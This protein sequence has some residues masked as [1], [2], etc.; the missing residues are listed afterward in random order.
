MSAMSGVMAPSRPVSAPGPMPSPFSLP[1][2]ALRI[3][4]KCALPLIAWFSAGQAVRFGLL[5]LG[6]EISHGDARQL[7]LV[8]TIAVLTLIVMASM[9]ITAGMLWSVRGALWEIRARRATGEEDERYWVSMN[10]V[11]P[12]F[13]VIYLTWGFH[14]EDA[15][16]F[17]QTDFL[18][19]IDDF[20]S[21]SFLGR[22]STVGR[23]LIDLD[24]RISFGLMAVAFLLRALF[25]KMV[26][27]GDGKIS[28]LGTALSEFA[29][30]FFG[31]NATFVLANARSDW[32]SHRL[33]VSASGELVTQAEQS[34][35]GWEA[36]WGAVGEIWPYI[37]DG[38]FIPLTWLTVAVLVFGTYAD[39][40]RTMLRDTR[41]EKGIDKLYSTHSITQ[42]SV[43]RITG[44]FQERWVPLANSF[45]QTLTGG[46][47]LFGM[48]CLCYVSL[49]VGAE[50]AMR[51]VRTLIGS[52]VE[53][54]WMLVGAPVDF[55]KNLL[56]TV[57]TMALLAA[58]FDIAAT[59]GRRMAP[60][61]EAPESPAVRGG[62]M[63]VNA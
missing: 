61:P 26:E 35:P 18:H 20:F 38:V 33:A 4:G 11:A 29:F 13:A 34:I 37:V 62:R 52:K 36:F 5:Y 24:W 48:M 10:R 46:V 23:G 51:G 14:V 6:T 7:R 47:A 53:W 40:A 42:K 28:G 2:H 57:L 21:D 60:A 22:S 50:Y 59:R 8:A 44:G 30:V 1:L 31:L 45:R 16:D 9:T 32:V 49:H 15:R 58:A 12:A 43:E 54:L 39:D 19:N 3:A 27:R 55:V 25:S 63:G 56:V 17:V 41:F